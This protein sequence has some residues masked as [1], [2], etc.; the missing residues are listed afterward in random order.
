MTNPKSA[1]RE[2]RFVAGTIING[3]IDRAFMSCF[4]YWVGRVSVEYWYSPL[5]LKSI[6]W[7]HPAHSLYIQKCIYNFVYTILSIYKFVYIQICIPLIILNIKLSSCFIISNNKML[8][9]YKLTT[10]VY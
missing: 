8:C 2:C 6:S 7:G 10:S 4:F 9:S 1:N 3:I 5:W